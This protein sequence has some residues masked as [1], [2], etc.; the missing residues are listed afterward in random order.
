MNLFITRI[1]SDAYS[2]YDCFLTNQYF[3]TTVFGCINIYELLAF[4]ESVDASSRGKLNESE[5]N[6]LYLL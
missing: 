4:S 6:K 3:L 5:I 1:Y 2:K